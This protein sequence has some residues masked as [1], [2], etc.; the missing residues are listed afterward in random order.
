MHSVVCRAAWVCCWSTWWHDTMC[1]LCWEWNL[2]F[3]ST[4][5]WVSHLSCNENHC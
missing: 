4:F 1:G 2:I 3:I 5:G